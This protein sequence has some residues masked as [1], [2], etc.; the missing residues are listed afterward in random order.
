MQPAAAAQLNSPALAGSGA[1]V[2]DI[3]RSNGAIASAEL[4]MLV[5]YRFD[6]QNAR[7]ATTR[8]TGLH[9]HT[10]SDA[11]TPVFDAGL[12]SIAIAPGGEGTLAGRILFDSTN[13]AAVSALEW[14]LLHP[15]DFYLDIHTTT[16]PQ[17]ALSGTLAVPEELSV[18]VTEFTGSGTGDATGARLAGTFATDVL[19]DVQGTIVA[20]LFSPTF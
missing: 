17:G 14:A 15:S 7:L 6:S 1:F 16:D 2:A 18:N 3:A 13:R 19:R 10:K 20:G 5:R 4:R 12:T 9:V 8:I 11:Q